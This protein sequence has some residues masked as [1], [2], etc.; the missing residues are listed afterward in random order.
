[1]IF[2]LTM[3]ATARGNVTEKLNGPSGSAPRSTEEGMRFRSTRASELLSCTKSSSLGTS[4]AHSRIA[5]EKSKSG[6]SLRTTFPIVS[7]LTRSCSRRLAT[8]SC[9]T[10][11]TTWLPSRSVALCTCAIEAQA[12]GV[13]ST[14]LNISSRGFFSSLSIRALTSGNPRAGS[15]SWHLPRC[16]TKGVGMKSCREERYC[17]I[18]TH[19]PSSATNLPYRKRALRSCAASQIAFLPSKSSSSRRSQRYWTSL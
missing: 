1:M 19:R 13:S 9:C 15:E 18:F 8:F 4:P 16:V 3:P 2:S 11:M 6:S 17:P 7:R 5:G 10:L 14:S 12:M